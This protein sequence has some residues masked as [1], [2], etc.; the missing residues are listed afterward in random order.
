MTCL[1]WRYPPTRMTVLF[2]AGTQLGF[3][4]SKIIEIIN[5]S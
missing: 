2:Y 1:M 5:I 3:I 4:C